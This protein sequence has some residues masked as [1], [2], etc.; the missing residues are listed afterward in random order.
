MLS[1]ESESKVAKL[2]VALSEGEKAVELSRQV[3]CDNLEFDAYQVFKELDIECKNKID[4]YN[5]SGFLQ[6]RNIF[7][8]LSDIQFIIR[9]YDADCDGSL[10]YCEFLNLVQSSTSFKRSTKITSD[11]IPFNVEYSFRKVIEKEIDLVKKLTVLIGDVKYRYDFNLHDIFH[12]LKSWNTITSESIKRFLCHHNVSHLESDIRAIMKRLDINRDN[13]VDLIEFSSF[14]GCPMCTCGQCSCCCCTCCQ[15]SSNL[16][17]SNHNSPLRQSQTIERA[18]LTEKEDKVTR[19]GFSNTNAFKA[20]F[21][22]TATPERNTRDNINQSYEIKKV[23][24]NLELRLSPERR[25]S[26]KR[27]INN[28][29]SPRNSPLRNSNNNMFSFQQ[30]NYEEE[31]FVDYLRTV[32]NE[33]SKVERMKIDL[34]LRSD[35]NVE[36]AYRL[37]E[38]NGRDYLTEDDLKYGLSLL[39][40][41]ST[42]QD[43][44]I[45][46]K[47]FDLQGK[48]VMNYADF[49]DMIIPYEKEYRSMAEKRSPNSCCSCKSIDAFSFCTRTYLQ[50]LLRNIISMENKLN[51]LKSGLTSLRCKLKGIFPSIDLIDRGY[52]T[53]VDLERYLKRK[54]AFSTIKDSDL[55]FIHLDRN[56]NGQVEYW[57]VSNALT[58]L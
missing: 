34:A 47:R 6:K 24:P 54:D 50:S 13:R 10:S 43:T 5:I 29:N 15:H 28:P 25:F 48:G 46:M 23:S 41:F 20:T 2:L 9:F 4:A 58:P 39:D 14:F 55:L 30:R 57:E 19:M 8:P 45:L 12:L 36:D 16:C 56:R 27:T 35:F 49:F 52:F 11:K 40:I 17:P 22:Q 42:D 18:T 38:L 3:L 32:M 1:N 51:T 33:E 53:E 7:T 21:F 31:Q 44:K 26:P 37:F